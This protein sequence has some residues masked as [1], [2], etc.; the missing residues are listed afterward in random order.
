MRGI[1]DEDDE[2]RNNAAYGVGVLCEAL[3]P[4]SVK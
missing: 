1:A 4:N 2:V 3:G